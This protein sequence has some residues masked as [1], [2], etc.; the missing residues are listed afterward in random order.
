MRF[1]P[2]FRSKDNIKVCRLR[3]AL[4]GLNRLLVVGL[5]S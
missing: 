3:K 2:G 1:P 4:Y 5:L